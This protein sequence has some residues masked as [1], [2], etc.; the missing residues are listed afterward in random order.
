MTK[1][2]S[3]VLEDGTTFTGLL[4]GA[5]VSVSGEVGKPRTH[6]PWILHSLG[7]SG[8]EL[9][10]ALCQSGDCVVVVVVVLLLLSVLFVTL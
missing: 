6:D 2:A 1:M 10:W 3:L 7:R 8:S 4:F 9:T 5:D